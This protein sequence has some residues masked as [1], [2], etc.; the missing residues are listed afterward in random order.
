[1]NKTNRYITSNFSSPYNTLWLST[2][3]I[4]SQLF[5]NIHRYNIPPVGTPTVDISSDQSHA[6]LRPSLPAGYW[7]FQSSINIMLKPPLR[8]GRLNKC[9]GHHRSRFRATGTVALAGRSSVRPGEAVRRRGPV[10]ILAGWLCRCVAAAA[11]GDITNHMARGLW[12]LSS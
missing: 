3:F 12:S 6:N 7:Y 8:S 9:G 2:L 5:I 4:L 10:Q 11:C 1:M